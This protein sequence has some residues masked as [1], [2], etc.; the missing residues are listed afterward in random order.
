MPLSLR[1]SRVFSQETVAVQGGGGEKKPCEN[2]QGIFVGRGCVGDFRVIKG[3]AHSRN[4]LDDESDRVFS[5]GKIAGFRKQGKRRGR[6][7]E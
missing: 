5:L 6:G 1:E 3:G 4:A 2:Q 7:G